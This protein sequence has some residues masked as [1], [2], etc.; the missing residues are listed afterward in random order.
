MTKQ[1]KIEQPSSIKGRRW[2]FAR[3]YAGGFGAEYG[4]TLD[5]R[6]VAACCKKKAGVGKLVNIKGV[7]H[8]RATKKSFHR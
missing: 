6:T 2:F 3:G 5:R 1:I 4:I 8:W 7:W